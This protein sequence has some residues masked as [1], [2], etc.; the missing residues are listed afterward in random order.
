MGEAAD[1]THSIAGFFNKSIVDQLLLFGWFLEARRGRSPFTG[2]QMRNC[3]RE[4]GLNPPDTSTYLARQ[5]RKKPPQLTKIG[6]GYRL[7]PALKRKYDA[8]FDN[9]PSV[10]AVSKLLTDLPSKVPNVVERDFLQE[11]LNCYQI[12]AYRA[13]IVMAWNLAYDHIVEWLLS[14]T[15]RIDQLNAGIVKRFPK[16]KLNITAREDFDELKESELIQACRT[17]RLLDKNTVQ[18]LEGKLTRRNSVAHP[19]R[20]VITQAQ[21]DDTITDLVN[22]VILA[23]N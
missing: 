10:I 18:I 16:K 11:T 17:A 23:L 5:A 14:E 7:A 4:A 22:N 1:F 2:E 20:I 3:F 19:S 9:E 21:A 15:A 8:K 13:S 12:K 6:H